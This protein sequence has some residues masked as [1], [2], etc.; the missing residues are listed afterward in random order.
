MENKTGKY[1]KY[2]IGEV[3]LVVIGILIAL[4]INNWNEQVKKDKN[5]ASVF[6]TVKKDLLSDISEV[7]E[8]IDFYE[9][10]DSLIELVLNRKVTKEDYQKKPN[11]RTIVMYYNELSINKLGYETLKENINDVPS[12][13]ENALIDINLIYTEILQRIEVNNKSSRQLLERTLQKWANNYNWYRTSRKTALTPNDDMI[14]FFL[15]DSSYLGDVRM[16]KMLGID[17]H[18]RAA[19]K[20]N[21]KAISALIKIDL[22]NN[23][24]FEESVKA[25]Q[26]SI[27]SFEL[28][29]MNP[30]K[31]FVFK[32]LTNSQPTLVF[33]NNAINEKLFIYYRNAEGL[34]VL[35]PS[36]K[37][38]IEP[39]AFNSFNLI[40]DFP[41]I[42]KDSIGNALGTFKTTQLNNFINL[43]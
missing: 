25:Y 5:I 9:E 6:E 24:T 35:I 28:I 26:N 4:S 20:Y 41:F 27:G 30:I 12:K 42:V 10:K 1:L 16:V 43:K 29:N 19:Q 32:Q 36:N 33:I 17:N 11:L 7:N 37:N 15:N 22:A 38:S 18:L 13:Y 3:V 8:F 34:D 39:K 31:E 21:L 2:A 14:N 23:I 40:K